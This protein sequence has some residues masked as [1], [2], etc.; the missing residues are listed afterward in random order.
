ME[1][2]P[3][4]I[5]EMLLTL[6]DPRRGQEVAYN[7]WYERDHFYAGCMIG[8]WLF[9]G[10]RWVA[11][12]ALKDLRI[13][14]GRGEVANPVDAGSYVSIYWVLAG[15]EQEHWDWAGKQ[16]HWLYSNGRGFAERDHVHTVLFQYLATAYRDRDPVPVQLALE[17]GYPGIAMLATDRAPGVS[18]ADFLRFTAGSKAIQSPGSRIASLASFRPKQRDAITSSSPMNLGT[19]TGG[20]ER[21][22][23]LAF[24]E[25]DPAQSFGEVAAHA[26]AIE[27]EGLGRVCFAAPFLRTVVGTDRYTDQL[28]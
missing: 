25:G 7:R 21:V 10:S 5:G 11:T 17:H 12:R 4:Q 24:L 19:G 6:V 1:D 8:P 20:P 3:I 13:S 22:M 26:R 18:E 9:A 23:Q 28:W 27:G 15:H 2:C 14:D 16:V